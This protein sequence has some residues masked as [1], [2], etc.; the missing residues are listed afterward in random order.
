MIYLEARFVQMETRFIKVL[1][2]LSAFIV[3]FYTGLSRLVDYAHRASDILGGAILGLIIALLMTLVVGKI[4]WIYEK[5]TNYQD[6]DLKQKKKASKQEN[7][8]IEMPQEIIGYY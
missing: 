6:P 3:A 8:E 7:Y 2:Q 5:K 1:L 4:I